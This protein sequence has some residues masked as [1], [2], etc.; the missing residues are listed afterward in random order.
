MRFAENAGAY[1]VGLDPSGDSPSA[2][3][4]SGH[5]SV[6]NIIEILEVFGL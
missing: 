6:S 4:K 5:R 2:F 3:E 1:F